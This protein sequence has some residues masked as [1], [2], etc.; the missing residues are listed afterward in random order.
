MFGGSLITA[1]AKVHCLLHELCLA[2]YFFQILNIMLMRDCIL[3]T[4]HWYEVMKL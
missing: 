3:F 1:I 2:G 4:K